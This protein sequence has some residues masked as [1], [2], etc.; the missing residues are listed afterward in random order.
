MFFSQLSTASVLQC[1]VQLT[2]FDLAAA[3]GGLSAAVRAQFRAVVASIEVPPLCVHQGLSLSWHPSARFKQLRYLEASVLPLDVRET[4]LPFPPHP[5][6]RV[7]FV[8]PLELHYRTFEN[9]LPLDH[10]FYNMPLELQLGAPRQVGGLAAVTAPLIGGELLTQLDGLGLYVEP[11]NSATR[12]GQ[13]F[14]FHAALLADALTQAVRD[15]L[16]E[17]MLDGF[18][19]VNPVFRC[20]RFFSGEAFPDHLDTPYCDPAQGHL[21]RW[22]MLVYLTGGSSAPDAPPALTIAGIGLDQIPAMTCVLIDQSLSHAGASFAAGVKVFLRTELIFSTNDVSQDANV[23]AL[24]AQACYLTGESQ[25]FPSLT[26]AANE[27]YERAA[28]AHWEGFTPSPPRAEAHLLKG[29]RGA[30][31]V[32]NGYD[33]WFSRQHLSVKACA[34]LAVL[35][36]LNCR[37]GDH[38]F[39]HLCHAE[40]VDGIPGGEWIA[41]HLL[42]RS[43][44][45]E[46]GPLDLDMLIPPPEAPSRFICCP[47]HRRYFDASRNKTVIEKYEFARRIT[48]EHLQSAPIL[49][50]GEEIFINEEHIVVHGQQIHLLGKERL[51]PLNFAAM[52]HV[53][54]FYGS[55]LR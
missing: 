38:S 36:Y 40:V 7:A 20:N 47:R 9:I 32:T 30:S 26:A 2:R 17:A 55:P 10:L 18:S 42:A 13:R 19:H 1:G 11:L 15:A 33:Y 45:L 24:F 37:I 43:A 46:L 48:T 54:D 49:L 25:V 3:S 5:R 27:R 44:P 29:F 39:R 31:F 16:P 12:G 34:A 4:F 51:A 41:A 23:G 35:D 14:I 28:R 50:M 53:C 21:S 22:T 6:P 8:D 52:E